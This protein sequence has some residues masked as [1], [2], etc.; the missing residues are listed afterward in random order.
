[1]ENGLFEQI[2]YMK[3]K[4]TLN[5]TIFVCFIVHTQWVSAQY[6]KGGSTKSWEQFSTV[7]DTTFTDVFVSSFPSTSKSYI[8][9][10]RNIPKG[11]IADNSETYYPEKGFK[12][13]GGHDM[14]TMNE[15]EFGGYRNLKNINESL[16][17]AIDLSWDF[18]VNFYWGRPKQI[19]S[20]PGYKVEYDLQYGLGY[21]AGLCGTIKPSFLIPDGPKILEDLFIDIGFRFN[22]LMSNPGGAEYS[23]TRT[24]GETF[25]EG[26]ISSF[27]ESLLLQLDQMPFIAI[28]YK[29]LGLRLEL[30]SMR[31]SNE[32]E[33]YHEYTEYV[34]NPLGSSYYEIFDLGADYKF[35]KL[36]FMLFF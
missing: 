32:P 28:R 36:S 34:T 7:Y 33:M 18:G 31:W 14:A 1:M 17:P 6:T 20:T 8:R 30:S 35:T 21:G 19:S 2:K 26:S 4:I 3:L 12:G 16:H 9:Y 29:S 25:V 15:V 23:G 13:I 5:L 22:A 11:I 24:T 10:S 27:E